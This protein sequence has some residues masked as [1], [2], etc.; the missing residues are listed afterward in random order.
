MPASGGAELLMATHQVTFLPDEKTVEV[1]TGALLTEAIQQA[2]LTFAQPC[3]GQGRCGRCAVDVAG[4]GIRRRSTIRLTP[5]DLASGRA[6]ACQSVIE[7]DLQITIPEQEAIER[8]LVTDKSARKIEVP[9]A[10]DPAR[11]QTVRA[12]RVSLQPPSLQ[13]S[14]DD[15][16]RVEAGLVSLGYPR[17]EVP[18]AVL[19]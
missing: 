1:P 10:Y 16:S 2:G 11:M 15:L 13:D 12:F 14:T 19:R 6:L 17:L 4:S 8:R 5:E 9:F 18:L 3:G 7:G